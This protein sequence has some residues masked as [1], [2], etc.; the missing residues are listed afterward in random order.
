LSSSSE[1]A[2]DANDV[3]PNIGFVVV[4]GVWFPALN[5]SG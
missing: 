1:D 3:L 4:Y 2:S 5:T